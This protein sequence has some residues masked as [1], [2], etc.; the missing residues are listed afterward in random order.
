[1]I[2]LFL[3][4]S[5][6]NSLKQLYGGDKIPCLTSHG[7]ALTTQN[8]QVLFVGRLYTTIM[9]MIYSPIREKNDS[10]KFWSNPPNCPLNHWI[11]MELFAHREDIMWQHQAEERQCDEKIVRNIKTIIFSKK[12]KNKHKNN[13]RRRLQTDAGAR[14]G[15]TLTDTGAHLC[16]LVGE[17]S[18]FP[19]ITVFKKKISSNPHICMYWSCCSDWQ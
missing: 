2:P 12:K 1:M 16:V 19:V 4:H 13:N 10:S 15:C 18:S 9:E 3:F 6:C 14:G 5:N 11:N 8:H 17:R 7:N